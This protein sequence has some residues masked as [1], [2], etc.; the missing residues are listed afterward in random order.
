MADTIG[1]AVRSIRLHCPLAP[2]FLAFNWT[3]DS[4]RT[5]CNKRGWSWLRANGEFIL[6]NQVTGTCNVTRGSATISGG[7]LSYAAANVDRQFRVGSAGAIYTITACAVGVSYTID[8]VY[9]GTTALA[10]TGT[11]LDAYL[12]CP[13]D[14]QRFIAVLDVVNNWQLVLWKTEDELNA[15]DAQ[16]SSTGTPIW[17]VSN[18]LKTAGTASLIG[19]A[20]YELWPY[21][22]SASYYPFFY[23]RKPEA[24]TEDTVLLG[25]LADYFEVIV[26]YGLAKAAQWPGVEGKRNPYFNLSLSAQLTKQADETLDRLQVLDEEIYMSWVATFSQYP[27]AG[28][29]DSKFMQ[30]HAF[31]AMGTFF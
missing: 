25:P 14:F 18:K 1:E 11:I 27:Y 5:I 20:Q 8:Q 23:M 19:R 30:S 12:T 3:Q 21:Q 22:T 24:L 10:T 28:V 26:Q 15:I 7:T 29:M 31:P 16:R 6:N 2:Y 17:V 4:Y 9:G 13:A